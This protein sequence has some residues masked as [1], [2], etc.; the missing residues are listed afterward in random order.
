VWWLTLDGANLYAGGTFANAGT[1]INKVAKFV[2]SAWSPVGAIANDGKINVAVANPSNGDIYVGGLFTS[3]GGVPITNLGKWDAATKSWVQVPSGSPDNEVLV[4]AFDGAN[5]LYVGGYFVA[6]SGTA[7]NKIARFNTSSNQWFTM[8]TGLNDYVQALAWDGSTNKLYAGGGFECPNGMTLSGTY[9][10]KT[11]ASSTAN[12]LGRVASWNGSTWSQLSTGTSN[13]VYALAV[14][15]AGKLYAGGFFTHVGATPA[16]NTAYWNGT[17]WSPMSTGTNEK[18]YAIT[19]KSPT[20]VFYGGWFTTAGGTSVNYVAKWDGTAWSALGTGTNFYVYALAND[21]ANVYVGGGF[22]TA[23]GNSYP[24]LAKWTGSAW[25]PVSN[26]T[27]ESYIWNIHYSPNY[28]LILTAPTSSSFGGTRSPMIATF[29]GQNF[30]TGRTDYISAVADNADSVALATSSAIYSAAGTINFHYRDGSTWATH[31][32][33][34]AKPV[35]AGTLTASGGD[36]IIWFASQEANPSAIKYLTYSG[37]NITPIST[38]M[39]GVNGSGGF[40]G[41]GIQS[42]SLCVDETKFAGI[43]K[44]LFNGWNYGEGY[45]STLSE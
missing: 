9:P 20:E 18:I 26:T 31:S 17:S 12:Y 7:Y 15:G 25:A 3:L 13:S 39:P 41:S 24:Y 29:G 2:S 1:G 16:N 38:I 6:I 23:G 43:T 10:T 44:I 36:I 14:D 5:N 22:S 35:S 32:I 30:I 4:L 34:N 19:V 11:C 21:G 33:A 37:G 45:L 40:L 42:T 8:G 27:T 28:G